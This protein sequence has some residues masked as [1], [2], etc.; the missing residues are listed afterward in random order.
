MATIEKS[1]EVGVPV[2][3]AYGQWTRFRGFRSSCQA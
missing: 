2:P 1:I 3:V